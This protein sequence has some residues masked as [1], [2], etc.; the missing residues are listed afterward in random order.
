[1]ILWM[2][3]NVLDLLIKLRFLGVSLLMHGLDVKTYWVLFKVDHLAKLHQILG[4]LQVKITNKM[5]IMLNKNTCQI[6]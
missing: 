6:V 1:M 5:I 2:C 4:N 3:L